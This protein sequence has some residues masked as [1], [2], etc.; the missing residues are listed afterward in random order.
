MP[1]HCLP[2]PDLTLILGPEDDA[3]FLGFADWPGPLN[4]RLRGM[5]YAV[6][7]RRHGVWT[8]IYRVAPDRTTDRLLVYLEKVL[9]GERLDD[10]RAWIAPALEAAGTT[11]RM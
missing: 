6:I 7:H 5:V 9:E 4:R 8:H 1:D 11:T 2:S 10:A 3:V